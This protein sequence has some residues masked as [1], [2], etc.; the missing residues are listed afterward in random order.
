MSTFNDKIKKKKKVNK[1]IIN[2][3]SGKYT[4]KALKTS[5]GACFNEIRTWESDPNVT[6]LNNKAVFSGSKWTL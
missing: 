4:E 1:D 6:I 5:R 2:N 3:D